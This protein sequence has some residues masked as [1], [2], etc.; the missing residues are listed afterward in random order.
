MCVS[1]SAEVRALIFQVK[2]RLGVTEIAMRNF[3]TS[4][5]MSILTNDQERA[6]EQLYYLSNF[7][8]RINALMV[9]SG[10]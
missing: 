9:H 1:H 10:E 4:S 6:E 8:N 7:G 5:W 2:A 3:I